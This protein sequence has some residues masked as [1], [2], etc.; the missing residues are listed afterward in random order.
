MDEGQVGEMKP[1]RFRALVVSARADGARG[2]EGFVPSVGSSGDVTAR[3]ARTYAGRAA[4]KKIR[5]NC[6]GR[7][8]LN[9]QHRS[10][11]AS[12]PDQ[13]GLSLEGR[14]TARRRRVLSPAARRAARPSGIDRVRNGY[15][16]D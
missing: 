14:R 3:S 4:G 8:Q 9:W 16:V 2:R 5:N 12:R 6:S 13:P 11:D 15:A 7:I 1:L 10:N